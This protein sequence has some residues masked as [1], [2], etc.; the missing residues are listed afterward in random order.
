MFKAMRVWVNE[1]DF[2]NVFLRRDQWDSLVSG[3]SLTRV[4]MEF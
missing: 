3:M 2:L 1:C 4:C